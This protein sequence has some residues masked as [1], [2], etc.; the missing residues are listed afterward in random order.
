MDF[1]LTSVDRRKAVFPLMCTLDYFG[2]RVLATS[3]LPISGDTL[4]YG[5]ADGGETVHTDMAEVNVWMAQASD[6]LNIKPHAIVE[7]S[8]GRRV[9]LHAPGDIEC[10]RGVGP[11]DGLFFVLDTHRVFPPAHRRGVKAPKGGHL[12][13][14]LRP[15]LVM[16]YRYDCL[17]PNTPTHKRVTRAYAGNKI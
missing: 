9:V 12:Y 8:S 15:E 16:K 3:V 13:Q 10:H 7:Q 4:V 6:Y 11:F 5:S 1:A 2:H 14:F 17:H